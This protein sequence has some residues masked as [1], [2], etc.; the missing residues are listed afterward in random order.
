MPEST[1]ASAPGPQQPDRVCGSKPSRIEESALRQWS[2]VKKFQAV[3]DEVS[4]EVE[5]HR[6]EHDPRRTL[7]RRDYFSLFL[8]GMFNPVLGSMRALCAASGL[9]RTRQALGTS[10]VSLGSFSEAQGLF[11]PQLLEAVLSRLVADLPAGA[12]SQIGGVDLACLRVVDSTLWYVLPR[13]DW[14]AWRSG[15][16]GHQQHGVRLHLKYRLADGVPVAGICSGGKLCERKALRQQLKAGEFY[17]GDRCYGQEYGFLEE[18]DGKGCGYLMRLKQNQVIVQTQHSRELSAQDL[19]AGV[20]RDEDVVLGRTARYE[21]GPFRL[22]VVDHAQMEEPVWLVTNQTPGQ[23]SAA[24][25]AQL[26]RRRWEVEGF[27]RWLKCLLPCRHWLAESENGVAI[28]IYTALICA[29]LLTQRLGR[30][31]SK[32]LMEMLAFHQM[33][34]ASDE[35]LAEAMRAEMR[36]AAHVRVPRYGTLLQ[37]PQA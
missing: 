9:R 26:Y 14:A 32:R 21:R 30:K 8:L 29:V 12:A 35:E 16:S 11:E 2:L 5:A 31:P 13:M 24:Q 6:T 36:R 34:Q 3:L 27:F 1:P 22:I 23:L 15:R 7:H 25:V 19:E 20:C 37:Q 10:P 4:P 28:Q 33:N 17:I 18:L